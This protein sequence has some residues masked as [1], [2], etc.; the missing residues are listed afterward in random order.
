MNISEIKASLPPTVGNTEH[1]CRVLDYVDQFRKTVQKAK[2]P[3]FT[4]EDWSGFAS[5]VD[6]ENFERV[7]HHCEV[8]RWDE[9]IGFVTQFATD[10]KWEGTFRRVQER[11]NVVYLELT[12]Y[13]SVGDHTQIANTMTVYRFNAS[14]KIDHLTVYIQQAPEQ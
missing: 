12:E 14:G 11:D 9:Y 1:C 5:L 4:I 6:T 3:G 7:G 10:L 13:A 8:M 2:Q